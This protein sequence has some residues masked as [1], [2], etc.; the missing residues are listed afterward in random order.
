[1]MDARAKHKNFFRQPADRP[2][3]GNRW[4]T[5]FNDMITLLMVFFVLLFSMGSLDVKRFKHFQNALQSAMGILNAGRHAPV[6]IITD[7]PPVPGQ[8]TESGEGTLPSGSRPSSEIDTRG[9]EAV[10]TS[11]GIHLTLDDKL[12]FGTGSTRLTAGGE[13]LLN[14]VS[15]IIKPLKRTIRVEGHTDN[16]PIATTDYPSNWELSTARAVSVVKYLI[17]A[18]GIAPRYLAAAGYG[19]S[20]PRAPND[21]ERN[22]SKNRRVEII[23]G[24]HAQFPGGK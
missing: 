9:L 1:M 15:H 20:R 21:T 6:G 11:D 14:R 5:T 4:L 23:L 17:H 12:L 10:Y 8:E 2:A 18:T 3:D 22:M 16:R 19:D 13:A 24:D 7:Q